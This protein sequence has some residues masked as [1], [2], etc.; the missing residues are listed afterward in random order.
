MIVGVLALQGDFEAHRKVLE[1]LGAE[2]REVR[3]P[4]DLEGIGGLVIP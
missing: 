2:V 3:T 1:G 4:G